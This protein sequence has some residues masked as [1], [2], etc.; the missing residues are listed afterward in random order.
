MLVGGNGNDILNGGNDNDTLV[1]GNGNDF[2]DGGGGDDQLTGG[3]GQN[4]LIGGSGTDTVAEAD[5]YGGRL[6]LYRS[7]TPLLTG[8]RPGQQ[9][10]TTINDQLSGATIEV[11]DLI[12]G[13]SDNT[14]NLGRVD[15]SRNSMNSTGPAAAPSMAVEGY[16]STWSSEA[17][18]SPT[19]SG[20]T[21]DRRGCRDL[22][23]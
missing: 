4:T 20:Q 14:F 7:M 6:R 3:F 17:A 5:F 18:P 16:D 19:R 1:G 12:G 2:L 9:L 11:A 10:R 13:P 8:H 21:R 22:R 15:R 23:Q